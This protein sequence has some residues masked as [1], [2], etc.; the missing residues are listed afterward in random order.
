[1]YV[2]IEIIFN[3][4]RS[5][6]QSSKEQLSKLRGFQAVFKQYETTHHSLA[7]VYSIGQSVQGKE[8]LVLQI[9]SGADK[10][11]EVGKPMLK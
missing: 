8:L 2:R 4:F 6:S 1:M 11:R 9:T 5:R 3:C 10:P 7:K